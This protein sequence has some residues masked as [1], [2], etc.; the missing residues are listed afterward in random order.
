MANSRETTLVCYA[1]DLLEIPV[2]SGVGSLPS[3]ALSGQAMHFGTALETRFDLSSSK[4]M[5]TI[6]VIALA[7]VPINKNYED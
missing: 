6:F 7:V 2:D 5:N 1:N 3:L 4:I